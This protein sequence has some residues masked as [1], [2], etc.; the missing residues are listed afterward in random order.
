MTWV[1][2]LQ[3]LEMYEWGDLN[4]HALHAVQEKK[5][6]LGFCGHH[7]HFAAEVRDRKAVIE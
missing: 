2:G 1:E 3:K 7:S 4:F 5:C 6:E